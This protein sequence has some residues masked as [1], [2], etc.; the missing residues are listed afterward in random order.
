MANKAHKAPRVKGFRPSVRRDQVMPQAL[1]VAATEEV[2][3][4]SNLGVLDT[5][6]L[7]HV[8][9]GVLLTRRP[10]SVIRR[11]A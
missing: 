5:R 1:A 4:V 9:D 7:A 2:P 6:V 3:E 10:I 8:G 11:P